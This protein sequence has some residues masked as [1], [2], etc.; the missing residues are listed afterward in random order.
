VSRLPAQHQHEH[1][2]R[3][4]LH[5]ELRQREV[6]SAVQDEEH[7]R[8]VPG[9]PDQDHRGQP[10]AGPRREHRRDDQRRRRHQLKRVVPQAETA[11]ERPA[12]EQS[13]AAEQ[14]QHEEDGAQVDRQR[15]ALGGAGDLDR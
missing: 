13:A 12:G 3:A 7:R 9:H 4:G 6:G 5:Q 1:H 15:A 14:D 11:R 10:A 8:R 2:H